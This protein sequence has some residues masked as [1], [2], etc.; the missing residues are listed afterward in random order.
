MVEARLRAPT[1]TQRDALRARIVLLADEGRSTRSI[2]QTVG[3]M[4]RSVSLWHGRYAREG[5]AGVAERQRRGPK[6]KY[7]ATTGQR[8]LA[9]LEH[10]P[11]AG[12]GHWTGPLIATELGD[13]HEQQV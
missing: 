8:I 5:L 12:F 2:A 7:T 1:T 13:V 11:P 4:P 6:P 3:T 9:V 10:P